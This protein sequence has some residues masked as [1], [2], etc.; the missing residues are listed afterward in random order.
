MLSSDFMLSDQKQKPK[1]M[2]WTAIFFAQNVWISKVAFNLEALPFELSSCPFQGM[3]VWISSFISLKS[4][5][6][7]PTFNGQI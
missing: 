5:D 3:T 6:P 7:G 4:R 2:L 1:K